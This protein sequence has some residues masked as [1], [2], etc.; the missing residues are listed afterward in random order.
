[1]I[2]PEAVERPFECKE[3]EV[4]GIK[5][6]V[7]YL[8]VSAGEESI[9]LHPFNTI[10]RTF[11][12]PDNIDHLEVRIDGQLQGIPMDTDTLEQF[13]EYNYPL[14][15]DLRPDRNTIDWLAGMAMKGLDDELSELDGSES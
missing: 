7:P 1:M 13:E 11:D 6:T 4:D 5:T 10:I 12:E 15:W 8:R 9:I 14:R 3:I 2:N